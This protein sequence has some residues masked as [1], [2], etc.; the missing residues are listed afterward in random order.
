MESVEK[1]V[2]ESIAAIVGDLLRTS[3]IPEANLKDDLDFDCISFL[4]LSFD[5]G[6][7]VED[8]SK[9]KTVQDVIMLC[10]Q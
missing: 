5:L 2:V 6:I 9:A 1:K 4:L 3:V 8:L 7:E 10:K